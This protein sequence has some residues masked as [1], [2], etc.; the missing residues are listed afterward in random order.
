MWKEVPAARGG[1]QDW[2]SLQAKGACPR[3]PGHPLGIGQHL[4]GAWREDGSEEVSTGLALRLS[5]EKSILLEGTRGSNALAGRAAAKALLPP[6][7]EGEMLAVG[8]WQPLALHAPGPGMSA[9][10]WSGSG[11]A[12]F[13]KLCLF[14]FLLSVSTLECA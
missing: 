14:F 7:A 12:E 8:V 10:D 9:S 11:R 1:T 6:W 3:P 4:G 13:A 5:Q 2:D